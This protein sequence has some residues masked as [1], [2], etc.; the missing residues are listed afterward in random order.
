MNQAAYHPVLD[1]AVAPPFPEAALPVLRNP[2]LRKNVAHAIDVIQAKRGR[3]VEEKAD[4]QELRT[5]A[6]A[7]RAH[8]LANL[9]A[10]LEEFEAR[11]TAAGGVVHWASDAAEARQIILQLL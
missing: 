6:A 8:A 5:A 10:Y 3:L 7:I 4:W 11:C 2:Q 9:G 1:P